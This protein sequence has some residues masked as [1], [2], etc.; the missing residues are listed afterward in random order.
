MDCISEHC[1]ENGFELGGRTADDLQHLGC[2]ALLLPRLGELTGARLKLLLKLECVRLEL[3]FRCRL[4]FLRPAEMTHAGHPQ[5]EDPPIRKHTT[6]APLLCETVHVAGPQVTSRDYPS[7][8]PSPVPAPLTTAMRPQASIQNISGSSQ[9]LAPAW[10]IEWEDAD[11]PSGETHAARS[12]QSSG[13]HQPFGRHG[14]RVA[15]RSARA[16]ARRN[17]ANRRPVRPRAIRK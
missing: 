5:A 10:V 2:R 7:P 4:R 16:A 17:A 12:A 9:G 6:P 3:L 8:A 15:A 14:V 13:F 11:R 1:L